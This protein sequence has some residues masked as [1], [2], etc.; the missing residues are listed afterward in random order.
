MIPVGEPGAVQEL[1]LLVKKNG[2]IEKTRLTFVRFVPFRRA[3]S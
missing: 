2:K 1:M 3:K